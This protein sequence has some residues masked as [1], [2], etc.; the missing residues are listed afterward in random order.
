MEE[1]TSDTAVISE[2][3]QIVRQ[4]ASDA[5][6]KAA[7]M[8]VDNKTSC[9]AALDMGKTINGLIK[10]ANEYFGPVVKMAH[11]THK[12]LKAKQNEVV[13]PLEAIKKVLGGKVSEYN[14]EL[15]RKQQ[16]EESRLQKIAEKAAE[17]ERKQLETEAEAAADKGDEE[18]FHRAKMESENVTA[19]SQMA[20]SQP[21]EKVKGVGHNW[22]IKSVDL[23]MLLK[24]V[25]DGR[26][27]MACIIADDK[28]L[29]NR[30]KME[31]D[32]LKI[33]GVVVKD[34][35]TVRFG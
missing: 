1:K 4:Q 3:E 17:E 16:E 12:A 26:A 14:L 13:Q 20:V 9:D 18:A 34:K 23:P 5:I 11:E 2:D 7:G 30:A 27:P 15:Q 21:K 32:Q 25:I 35:G 10:A 33:P 31:G 8:D 24:A 22:Q 29:L 19:E 6:Q 28:Y